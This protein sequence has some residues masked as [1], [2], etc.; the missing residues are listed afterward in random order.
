MCQMRHGTQP[1][2]DAPEAQRPVMRG[3][4]DAST[5]SAAAIARTSA[6]STVRTTARPDARPANI[7]VALPWRVGGVH[8]GGVVSLK[9]LARARGSTALVWTHLG[10]V[11]RG[12]RLGEVDRVAIERHEDEE[13][14]G[15]ATC[16]DVCVSVLVAHNTGVGPASQRRRPQSWPLAHDPERHGTDREPWV[17]LGAGCVAAPSRTSLFSSCCV[18]PTCYRPVSSRGS[19]SR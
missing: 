14:G 17:W 16:M 8:Y 13:K 7:R 18:G 10:A 2:V 1:P 12:H 6:A 19:R 9:L 11:D 4:S 5:S 3:P 15:K